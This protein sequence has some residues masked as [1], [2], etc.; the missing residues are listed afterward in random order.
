MKRIFWLL[1]IFATAEFAV[2]SL[3]KA[4]QKNFWGDEYFE[5][6]FVIVKRGFKELLWRGADGTPSLS[7]LHYLIERYWVR[8]VL[9]FER[10]FHWGL[11]WR[12]SFRFL[13]T[14]FLAGL[15]LF[16]SAI[17][18]R[19]VFPLAALFYV[20]FFSLHSHVVW[21]AIETRIYAL[22]GALSALLYI[23]S[24]GMAVRGFKNRDIFWWGFIC[25]C[26]SLTV[27]TAPVQI[28]AVGVTLLIFAFVKKNLDWKLAAKIL[29][30]S[31]LAA[32]TSLFY[33]I[34]CG[35]ERGTPMP[36]S[37]FFH[38]MPSA[39]IIFSE[40]FDVVGGLS[41]FWLLFVSSCALCLAYFL[42][43]SSNEIRKPLLLIVGGLGLS[44]TGCNIFLRLAHFK[45]NYMFA[46]RHA[47]Y[48]PA[49]FALVVGTL[50]AFLTE[51][52][53]DH[54]KVRKPEIKFSAYVVAAIVTGTLFSPL[55]LD[56]LISFPKNAA[57]LLKSWGPA[58]SG[59]VRLADVDANFNKLNTA[60]H[61][62]QCEEPDP[63]NP[64]NFTQY[65]GP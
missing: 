14:F 47:S 61:L 56:R 43:R 49:I 38:Q 13:Q 29:S 40:A 16:V 32:L 4:S 45:H 65:K 57:G 30:I 44:Q 27:N 20:L 46:E 23:W 53:L 5:L 8:G 12:V 60:V 18:L 25:A 64:K 37:Q 63:L 26:L 11:D 3:L 19:R 31:G 24:T 50:I 41:G 7:P 17:W 36:W 48:L 9:T 58:C 6:T 39:H 54:F 59:G 21:M 35:W 2:Y 51:K 1:L 42:L 10:Y 15:G 55:W 33:D 22:W 52:A 34:R 28:A 62:N